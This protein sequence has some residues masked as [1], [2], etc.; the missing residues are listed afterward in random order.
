MLESINPIFIGIILMSVFLIIWFFTKSITRAFIG[1][2]ISGFLLLALRIYVY[3]FNVNWSALDM[4]IQLAIMS[5]IVAISLI[6]SIL[7]IKRASNTPT[8]GK[9]A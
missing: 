7:L 9:T 6:G 4:Q 8:M 1:M 2:G 3:I 5:M